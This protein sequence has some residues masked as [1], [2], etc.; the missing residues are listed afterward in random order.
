MKAREWEKKTKFFHERIRGTK[1]KCDRERST[2]KPLWWLSLGYTFLW[3][4]G[5]FKVVEIFAVVLDNSELF[6]AG[7]L[8]EKKPSKGFSHLGKNRRSAAERKFEYLTSNFNLAA[9][10]RSVY[11][12]KKTTKG[13][14]NNR[15][16]KRERDWVPLETFVRRGLEIKHSFERA[17]CSRPIPGN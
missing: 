8:S 6:P 10:W 12:S 5:N 11:W 13:L 7:P 16:Y 3:D 4:S 2:E 14:K 15:Q 17:F 9:C 1:K